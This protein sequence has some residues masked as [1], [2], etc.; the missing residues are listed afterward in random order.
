MKRSNPFKE[1][2]LST[3]FD[4]S[5][6]IIIDTYSL[7]SLFCFN[8]KICFLRNL[9]MNSEHFGSSLFFNSDE[10]IEMVKNCSFHVVYDP[11]LILFIN[12]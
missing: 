10:T 7:K 8:Y 12:R 2:D 11:L 6:L 1:F 9:K 3:F 4:A 5:L